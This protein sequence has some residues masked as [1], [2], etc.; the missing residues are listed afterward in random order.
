MCD[1][2]PAFLSDD[3]KLGQQLAEIVSN[4]LLGSGLFV[5]LDPRSFIQRVTDFNVA[6]R[7]ADWASIGAEALVVGRVNRTAD[8]RLQAEY[9]VYDTILNKQLAGQRFA[10]AAASRFATGSRSARGSAPCR[11]GDA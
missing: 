1:L 7:Y 4:D 9:R 3:P 2:R 11:R 5:P 8:G 10:T 6:P